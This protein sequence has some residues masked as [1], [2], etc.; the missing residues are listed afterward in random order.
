MPYIRSAQRFDD[1]PR[2]TPLQV[3]ILSSLPPAPRLALLPERLQSLPQ[4]PPFP[5]ALP[6]HAAAWPRPP[7]LEALE[8]LEETTKRAELTLTFGMRPGDMI[9]CSVRFKWKASEGGSE[10]AR[11]RGSEGARER[12]RERGREG[13]RGRETDRQEGM[14]ETTHRSRRMS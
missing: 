13:E 8:V 1:V 5:I 11:E 10:G 2:L 9:V 6:P 3:S 7:K 14:Q 12:A 4:V